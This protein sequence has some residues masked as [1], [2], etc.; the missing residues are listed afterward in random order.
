MH[1]FGIVSRIFDKI[2]AT[3]KTKR[4]VVRLGALKSVDPETFKE[5]FS[6]IAQ[7]TPLEN[8]EVKIEIVPLI[9][10]CPNCGFKGE[11]RDIPHLHTVFL[12]WPCPKCGAEAEILSGNEEEIVELE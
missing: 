10:K 5:M 7:G 2:R 11:I 1:E 9:V 6:S 12:S 8:M 4:V 3:R